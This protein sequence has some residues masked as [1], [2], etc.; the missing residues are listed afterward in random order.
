MAIG[1]IP[2]FTGDGNIPFDPLPTRYFIRA[3]M[4][5][6]NPAPAVGSDPG[7]AVVHAV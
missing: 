7:E 1:R 2:L 6:I 4:L 5:E 3:P